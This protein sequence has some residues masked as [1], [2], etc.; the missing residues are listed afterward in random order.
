MDVVEKDRTVT[1]FGK[2]SLQFLGHTISAAGAAPAPEKIAAVQR[3]PKPSTLKG[4]QEFTGMLNFYHRFIPGAMRTM[5]P[6]FTLMATKEKTLSWS[7]V[8][9]RAFIATK[10]ALARARLLEHPRPKAHTDV[11]VPSSPVV[12]PH[13]RVKVFSLIQTSLTQQ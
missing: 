13:W 5:R 8:A 9:D 12:Q 1:T 6:L 10:E 2:E 4:L 11:R 3:F 7:E